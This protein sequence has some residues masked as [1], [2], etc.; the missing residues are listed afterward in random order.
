VGA[1]AGELTA[2]LYSD[3]TEDDIDRIFDDVERWEEQGIALA[4][5]TGGL[6]AAMSGGSANVG[7]SAGANAAEN[8]ALFI[9]PIIIGAIKVLDVALTA[10]D[11]Y[12]L[13]VELEACNN[14]DQAACHRA[15]ILAADLGFEAMAGTFVPGSRI[16]KGVSRWLGRRIA[17]TGGNAGKVADD[18]PPSNSQIDG[19]DGGS[20]GATGVN[21]SLNGGRPP[22]TNPTPQQLAAAN[23]RGVDPRWVNADGSLD[24]PPNNG[25]AGTPEAVNLQPGTRIDRYGDDSGSFLSPAGTPFEQRALP[26]SSANEQFQ[27]FEVVKPLP[28]SSG[29]AV[30]WFGQPGGG[31]QY[32]LQ[33]TDV[34][35]LLTEGYLRVVD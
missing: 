33:G 10:Y 25:F 18:L 19:P 2:M 26:S 5:I 31:T 24:Y 15:E 3:A 4:T 28:V 32:Q 13:S 34:K 29:K 16:L 35:S 9:I 8:N 11:M 1:F 30:P 14:Y 7:G 20:G 21:G 12:Q 6:A 27:T 17:R 22:V 23:D